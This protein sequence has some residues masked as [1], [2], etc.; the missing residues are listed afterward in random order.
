VIGLQKQ[1]PDR[2]TYIFKPSLNYEH[3]D[4][5]KDNPI[6]ADVRV[7]QALLY[8]I[9]RKTLVQKLFEGKQT[10]ADTWVNPLDPNHTDDVAKYPYDPA[11]AKQL[12]AEAGWTPGGDGICRNPQ[13]QR[14]SIQFSTTAGNRLRELQEQVLQSNWKQ[15]CIEVTIKNEPP[16]TLF[17]ETLKQRTYPGMVM[18]G[19][20]SAVGESPERTLGTADIP[21]KANNYGG[22]NYI[23][24][25]NPQMD[26]DIA[27]ATVEL[28]PAKQKPIWADMQKIYADQVPVLPLFFRAEA[29]V[30]P[31]WLKGY[32]PTGQ[33][34]MSPTWSENWHP[35]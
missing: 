30:I 13:G 9:D 32:T 18:Y 21:T 8:A 33:G 28:D 14:L 22:S 11:K 20:T 15:S 4:L 31:K 16:R 1:Y 5:Q 2:F 35:G 7:R 29:H 6:L 34:D 23:A 12:L 25:S 24:F 17:G 10:V 27:K 19:W 26:A 3:I